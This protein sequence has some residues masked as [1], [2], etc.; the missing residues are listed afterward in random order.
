MRFLIERVKSAN[1]YI[2]KKIHS[3]IGQGLLVYVAFE[4]KDSKEVI[5]KAASKIT[6][7][8]IFPDE[9]QKLNLSL[10]DK[11]GELM[12]ISSF[13]LFAELRNGLRP[14]FSRS[15]SYALGEPL[16]KEAINEF[17][18]ICH[19]EIGVFGADMQI[20]SVND[21]PVSVILDF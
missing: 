5:E 10:L 8:R 15:V 21:G 7:L 6:K 18:K 20:E 16:F 11:G 1:C 9:Q 3:S 13:S 17:K 14:S 2:D 19:T 12:L 4:E